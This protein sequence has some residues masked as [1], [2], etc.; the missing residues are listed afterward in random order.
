MPNRIIPLL[1]ISCGALTT[2]YVGL[3][4]TTI[5]FAAWQTNAMSSVRNTESAIGNLESNYYSAINRISSLNPSTLGFVSPARVEYVSKVL[6]TSTGLS[7]NG[8]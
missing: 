5:F 6:D 7:I 8:N 4:V 3:V 2:L 1:G